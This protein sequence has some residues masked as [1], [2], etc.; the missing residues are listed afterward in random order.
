MTSTQ[1]TPLPY[2][3]DWTA[4]A[5]V[6]T[7]AVLVLFAASR[8]S[9]AAF[10]TEREYDEGVY[11]LSARALLTGHA[12]F[13]Q[14]FSSQ[15]PAFLETLA[16]A[17]RMA[18]DSLW[19][20]RVLSITFAVAAL[21]AIADIGRRIGGAAAGP[22]AACALALSFTFVD[23]GHI[24]Q[25]ET[26]SL[27]FALLSIDVVLSAR[28]RDWNR[29]LLLAAGVLYGVAL[30][31]KLLA[32]PLV[33]PLVLV[34][35]LAA[36]D[37]DENRWR[38]DGRGIALLRASALR[39]AWIGAGAIV[40]VCIPLLAFDRG[41]L[42]D[43]AVLFHFAKHEAYH[44]HS[45]ANMERA[46]GVALGDGAISAAGAAAL[47]VGAW[48]RPLVA[49]WIFAWLAA[50]LAF[51]AE[52]T[53]LFWR[54]F[55]L[56]APPAALAA[57]LLPALVI[58]ASLRGGRLLAALVMIGAW[59]A[60]LSNNVG[61][62][63]AMFPLLH[64]PRNHAAASRVETTAAWVR[65]HTR[66]EDEI[67]TDDPILIYLAGRQTPPGLCDTSEARIV[68]GSLTLRDVV[69]QSAGVHMVVIH[70][71]GRLLT[72]A[73]ILPWLKKN[74]TEI[75]PEQSGLDSDRLIWLRS[76]RI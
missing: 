23:L 34:A 30:M 11:L 19:N 21:A 55:V 3:R 52:Q 66:P 57:S 41:A 38:V 1:K 60:M 40:V 27:A 22:V 74:F 68:S 16:Q 48:R 14:V 50:S 5:P 13:T 43:Q 51:L 17:M 24:V 53:P 7:A 32:I 72:L 56:I 70:R 64:D 18:G 47:L 28:R 71:K 26:P 42:I 69:V 75:S 46:W 67:L 63:E 35:F 10:P 2:A 44:L 8:L 49:A 45:L 54:H 9:I 59:V 62:G 76:S 61:K 65:D 15:P 36:A 33:V 12:L 6:C 73:G 31:F 25:A 20:A 58:P 29:R 4:W 39:I 37:D